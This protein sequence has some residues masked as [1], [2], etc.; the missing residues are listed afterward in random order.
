[1]DLP[2]PQAGDPLSQPTRARLFALLAKLKRP[3][4]TEE[5]AR[6]LELH[7]NGVRVHLLRLQ[8]A[9]LVTREQRRLPRGRPQD[10]WSIAPDARPGGGPPQAYED[11]SRWLAAAVTPSRARLREVQATGREIGRG[12][13]PTGSAPAAEAMRT[14][15]SALGFDPTVESAP[16]GFRCRL[17]NCPYREAVK[18]NQEMVCTLHRGITDGLLEVIEPEARLVDFVPRDPDSA[19][20]LI[21][22]GL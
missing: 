13:A 9:G 7:S 2:S 5:L 1:M 15:L 18:Q 6:E 19:G 8:E 11:L 21:E 10:A 22:V 14:T 20:C 4:A 3:A 17:G 12:L 16:D